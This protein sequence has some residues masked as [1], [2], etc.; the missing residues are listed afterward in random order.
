LA[1]LDG[2]AERAGA[3]LGAHGATMNSE[4]RAGAKAM[5]AS[6]SSAGR[7]ES[8][9]DILY[10]LAAPGSW[11]RRRRQ[12]VKTQA[13]AAKRSLLLRTISS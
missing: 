8:R 2:F 6:V 3:Q 11:R 5:H 4:A 13:P 12:R 1:T 7:P 9:N 10:C